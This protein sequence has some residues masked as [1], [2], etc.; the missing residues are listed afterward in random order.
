VKLERQEAIA[1]AQVRFAIKGEVIS[2]PDLRTRQ[3]VSLHDAIHGRWKDYYGGSRFVATV[4]F[5][6]HR[7]FP[8]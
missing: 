1:D 5:L 2:K 7:N 8:P 4:P 3:S 6:M